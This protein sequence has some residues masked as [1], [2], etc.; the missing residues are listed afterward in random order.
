MTDINSTA[1]P[2][3]T[4]PARMQAQTDTMR[5]HS[6]MSRIVCALRGGGQCPPAADWRQGFRHAM[7]FPKRMS[8]QCRH[9]HPSCRRCP[10]T[11]PGDLD[12]A[13]AVRDGGVD[14][15]EPRARAG[16]RDRLS[17]RADHR[18]A[19]PRCGLRCAPPWSL[20]R[21]TDVYSRT[22]SASLS[23]SLPLLAWRHGRRHMGRDG[24]WI[25]SGFMERDGV[26]PHAPCACCQALLD[27]FGVSTIVLS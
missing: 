11:K 19:L 27:T 12:N 24:R 6:S 7:D 2:A 9:R 14:G 25:P 16:H 22:T 21:F 13:D 3:Y 26:L 8:V 17:H 18:L 1:K 4:A 15:D 20:G 10:R 23:R 5:S